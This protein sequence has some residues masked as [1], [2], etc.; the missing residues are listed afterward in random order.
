MNFYLDSFFFFSYN[1]KSFLM[2]KNPVY[3]FIIQMAYSECTIKSIHILNR[4][5]IFLK[6]L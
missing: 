2:H 3:L 4:K 6:L 5:S 1:Q